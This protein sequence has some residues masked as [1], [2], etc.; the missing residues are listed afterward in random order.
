[1][2][3]STAKNHEMGLSLYAVV[4]RCA[5]HGNTAAPLWGENPPARGALCLPL[6]SCACRHRRETRQL[7][8]RNLPAAGERAARSSI[9]VWCCYL[10]GVP[11]NFDLDH[12]WRVWASGRQSALACRF[13]VMVGAV[14]RVTVCWIGFGISFKALSRS[15]K[16]ASDN[17]WE[18]VIASTKV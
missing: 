17:I 13:L 18:N 15:M 6:R 7:C 4:F 2:P 10:A 14:K 8:E 12:C 9:P 11:E 1:M 3:G 5:T 16:R